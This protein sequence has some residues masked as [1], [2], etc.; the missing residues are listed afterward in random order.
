LASLSSDA[1]LLDR[2]QRIQLVLDS[3]TVLAD[4][5]TAADIGLIET[6]VLG[7]QVSGHYLLEMKQP[8]LIVAQAQV[9][10]LLQGYLSMIV[11]LTGAVESSL[12]AEILQRY[13]FPPMPFV[14]SDS[15][16]P[17]REVEDAHAMGAALTTAVSSMVH[18]VVLWQQLR[19]EAE[20]QCSVS[21]PSACGLDCN[22]GS[23]R[24]RAAN[25]ACSASELSL[26][27]A[28]SLQLRANNTVLAT[29]TQLTAIS[30]ALSAC[31]SSAP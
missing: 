31:S 24:V 12:G 1:I 30:T 28:D 22:S 26:T 27:L 2:L 14:G 7:I 18:Y 21:G 3:L 23:H 11:Q 4:N 6:A 25:P 16:C 20:L 19:S 15:S 29:L 9:S 8:F 17:H 13:D 10:P 5:A